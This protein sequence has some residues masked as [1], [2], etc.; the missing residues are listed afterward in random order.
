MK[1]IV[2]LIGPSASGKTSLGNYLKNYL[3]CNEIISDT[4]RQP[5][6]GEI[7]GKDYY[8]RTDTEFDELDML[9]EVKYAGNRYGTSVNEIESKAKKEGPA[10]FAVVTYEGYK[11]MKRLYPNTISVYINTSKQNCIK[12][13]EERG[14]SIEEI[15][16]RIINYQAEQEFDNIKKCDFVV[17][18]ECFED[19]ANQLKSILHKITKK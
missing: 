17:D 11:N 4:T 5:R 13:M 10:L 14:D 7:H 6:A 8:F 2:C 1:T 19:A 16:K 18:N 3:G 9:E 12:R 15:A